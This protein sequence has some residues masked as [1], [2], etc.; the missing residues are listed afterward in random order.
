MLAPERRSRGDLIAAALIVVFVIVAATVVWLRSDARGTT[1][2]T[3]EFPAVQPET[4]LSVPENL[5][6]RWRADSGVTDLPLVAEGAVVTADGDAV[7]G[8]DPATGD[9]IW[10]YQRNMPLCDVISAWGD[11]VAVYRDRRGCSQVTA[12]RGSDGLR[13]GNRTSDADDAVT[14]GFDGTYVRSQGATRIELWRSDLVRTVE[15]GRIDAPVNPNSQPRSGCTIDSAASSSSKLAVLE[16]CPG[17]PTDRLTVQNPAPKD[18]QKPEE[19]G[20]VVLEELSPGTSGVRILA[21]AGDKTALYLPGDG[22]ASKPRIGVFD[23][24]AK[25]IAQYP[26]PALLS[27]D[28][29]VSKVGTGYNIWTGSQVVALSSTDLAPLWTFDGAL[30]PGGA[31]AGRTLIPVADGIA[32]VDPITGQQQSRITFARNDSASGP[33]TTAVLGNYVFEQRG[34]QLVALG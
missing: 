7:I 28:A 24:N 21:T 32:V 16:R 3:A 25:A 18:A 34:S 6:E 9:E 23:G 8:R 29:K 13:Q 2:I 1:S 27:P 15:Y 30:G 20:S 19:S 12:L 26:L 5:G 14:L 10:R 33:I 11:V 22:G 17:E 4:A 31:M